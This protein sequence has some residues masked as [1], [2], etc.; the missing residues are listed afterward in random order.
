MACTVM[1]CGGGR[2]LGLVA[3]LGKAAGPRHTAHVRQRR[4]GAGSC[5]A[6][7]SGGGRGRALLL[8]CSV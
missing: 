6:A 5:H 7:G 2:K 4:N 1:W 3:Q 8:L